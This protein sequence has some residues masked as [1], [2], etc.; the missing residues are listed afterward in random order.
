MM[1]LLL[2][3]AFAVLLLVLRA[4]SLRKRPPQTLRLQR[5]LRAAIPAHVLLALLFA[6]WLLTL[7]PA[8]WPAP[9]HIATLVLPPLA[10]AL[11]IEALA[12][13]F[14]GPPATGADPARTAGNRGRA[15]ADA[16]GD[17]RADARHD[18]R[19]GARA[20]GHHE[21]RETR[22]DAA[23]KGLTV[24]DIMVPRA[25]IVGLDLQGSRE[26]M[27]ALLA[28]APHTRLPVFDGDIDHIAGILH[29]RD[30][31]RLLHKQRFDAD[32]V[33][34]L[35]RPAYFIPDHTPLD[36]QLQEFRRARRQFAVVV[37]EYG[38]VQ[39]VI[40]LADLIAE[41]SGLYGEEQRDEIASDGSVLLDGSTP[42][43]EL[44]RRRQWRLPLD[45]PKTLNGLI[46]EA[47][48]TVPSNGTCL[49]LHGYPVEIVHVRDNRV[50]RVRVHPQLYCEE[51]Y[52]EGA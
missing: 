3:L 12:Q 36:K 26:D 23:G 40:G 18:A 43:R 33:R 19:S 20:D 49:R 6:A 1:S 35:L 5:L 31:L 29:A 11:A 42:V 25:R 51:A 32:D 38:E 14:A 7:L 39:G 30:A 4:A 9:A 13:Q 37:D 22:A 48:E 52:R 10:L 2:I 34:A 17:A 15:R 45:G 44:V 46:L 28:H 24:N 41:L 27:R 16:R 50:A 8:G 21:P 47:L